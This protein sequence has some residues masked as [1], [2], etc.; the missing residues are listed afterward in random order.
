M[1]KS[2]AARFCPRSDTDIC[3]VARPIPFFASLQ[4]SADVEFLFTKI[5]D[6]I[7]AMV[8]IADENGDCECTDDDQSARTWAS[9]NS[10]GD[11]VDQTCL[12]LATSGK[13]QD[14]GVA[15]HCQCACKTF[16]VPGKDCD[17]LGVGRVVAAIDDMLGQNGVQFCRNLGIPKPL[18]KFVGPLAV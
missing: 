18:C 2:V 17:M 1:S 13:C 4:V 16:L 8:N 7:E 11:G 6:L 5:A 9:A 14:S 3:P 12:I 15:G 10:V